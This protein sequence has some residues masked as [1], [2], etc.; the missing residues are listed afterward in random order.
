MF[1]LQNT[2]VALFY[3][4]TMPKCTFQSEVRNSLSALEPHS[5]DFLGNQHRAKKLSPKITHHFKVQCESKATLPKPS[6]LSTLFLLDIGYHIFFS[7]FTNIIV[8]IIIIT[9]IKQTHMCRLL[10]LPTYVERCPDCL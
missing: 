3:F 6:H 9:Y 1:P 4:D 8:D 5:M 10:L 2:L 7:V